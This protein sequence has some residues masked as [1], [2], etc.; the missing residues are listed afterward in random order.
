DPTLRGSGRRGVDQAVAG[1]LDFL[2]GKVDT[3]YLTVDM[4]VLDPGVAPGAPASTPGGM[5]TEELFE[6]VR[7]AGTHPKVK[8]MDLVCLDPHRDVREVTVKAG[9][10]TMLSFL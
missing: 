8:A 6:A 7:I 10:H 1:A 3:I 5:R 4:D 2:A 9:V